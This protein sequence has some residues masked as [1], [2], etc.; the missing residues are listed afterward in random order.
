MLNKNTN[1]IAIVESQNGS[2]KF[3]NLEKG[4]YIVIFNYDKSKYSLTKYQAEN[5]SQDMNSD[6]ENNKITIEGKEQ[7]L[8]ITDI[9]TIE[10]KDITNIDLGL[11]SAQ[12]FDL[13]LTKT[14]SKISINN[15][16]G[17]SDKEYDNVNMAKVEIPA[18]ALKGSVVAIEYKIGVKNNGDIAGY[19]KQ[20]VDY[21]PADLNF[22]SS[23]NK[24]WYQSGEYIYSKA[25][26]KEEIQ[27]GETKE[28]TLVLTKTMTESNTGLT[29]NIAEIADATSLN[30]TADVDSTFG[31]KKSGEDDLGEANVIVGIKTGLTTNILTI[32][33][34]LL[35]TMT[36]LEICFIRKNKTKI[37]N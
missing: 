36:I 6:A 19:A 37:D 8:A 22:N 7:Q 12:K 34:I 20:I 15:A 14:V 33:F 25:L 16:N 28:L 27:P 17:T 21:K 9:I 32:V 3:E 1:S 18:K 13:E 31:N 5:V 26:E 35:V 29:N 2:Y 11:I 10:D 30:G 23:L 4:K 24:D